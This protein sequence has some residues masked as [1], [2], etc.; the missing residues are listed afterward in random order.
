MGLVVESGV[1]IAVGYELLL[2]EH[3]T[4][5]ALAVVTLVE[6][7][8][9]KISSTGC[10]LYVCRTPEGATTTTKTLAPLPT[11]NSAACRTNEAKSS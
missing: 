8:E 1:F 5:S 9:G 11:C 6:L 10:E 4:G 3:A 7:V 2:A